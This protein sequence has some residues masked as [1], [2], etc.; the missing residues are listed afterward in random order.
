MAAGHHRPAGPSSRAPEG[1]RPRL[2]A[3]SVRAGG[4]DTAG[5]VCLNRLARAL[6]GPET[7]TGASERHRAL[8][9]L[10][11]ETEHAAGA[12]PPRPNPLARLGR[13]ALIHLERALGFLEFTGALVA[14]TLPRLPRPHRLRWR[15]VIAAVEQ[16]GVHALPI[17]GLLAF[18]MGVVMAYQGGTVLQSYGANV[19]LV[20]LVGITILRELGPLLAAIIVAGRTGSSYAAEIGTMR[21]TEEVDALRTMGITPYEMLVLP[22]VLALVVAMPLLSLWA[23]IAGIFGGMMVASTLY[24]VSFL[25]FLDRLPTAVPVRM[26]WTGIGKTPVFALLIAMV[27]CY[28]GLKVRGSAE[29]VGRATTLAVVQSIFLVIIADALFSITFQQFGI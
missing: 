13:L 7:L 26:F 20:E 22:K 2:A 19:F 24:D 8:L 1:A 9:E 6:G 12:P 10:A 23:D 25:T 15:Q 27:G 11:T 17:V 21:I 18:L 29:E 28:Q 5:A 16:A 14:D 3:G 4:L